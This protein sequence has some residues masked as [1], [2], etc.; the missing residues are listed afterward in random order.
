MKKSSSFNVLLSEGVLQNRWRQNTKASFIR[1]PKNKFKSQ[2]LYL[3]L[4]I[5]IVL[6]VY[7]SLP[8]NR[9]HFTSYRHLQTPTQQHLN[10]V[11]TNSLVTYNAKY[12]LTK[13][14]VNVHDKTTI[15]KVGLIADLDTNSRTKREYEYSSFLKLGY[16]TISST[17]TSFDFKFDS[18]SKEISSGYSLKGNKLYS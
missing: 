9:Q 6:I 11:P 15:Y 8:T 16:V 10:E 14:I 5:L 2:F 1:I 3:I 4:F 18:E 12:P 17:H 7:I 13:P